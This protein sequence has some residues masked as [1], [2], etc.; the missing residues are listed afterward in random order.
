[1]PHIERSLFV[2]NWPFYPVNRRQ[3][4]ISPWIEAFTNA[5]EWVKKAIKN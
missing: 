1:M 5:R 2:W 4:N 3:D